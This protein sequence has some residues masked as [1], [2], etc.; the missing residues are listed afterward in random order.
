MYEIYDY[1][2]VI[3]KYISISIYVSCTW[4]CAYVVLEKQTILTL[5]GDG[6]GIFTIYHE[7]FSHHK[8]S[9]FWGRIGEGEREREEG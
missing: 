3:Y 8:G 6:S 7:I 2:V 4:L 5:R 9:V 1:Y